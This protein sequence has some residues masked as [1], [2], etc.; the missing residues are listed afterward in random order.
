[1]KQV[2]WIKHIFRSFLKEQKG[3]SLVELLVVMVIIGML[4]ALVGPK[5]FKHVDSARRKD[6]SAQIAMFEEAIDLYRLEKH[7]YPASLEDLKEFMKKEIPQDP[8][9]K[10]Y[11]YNRPGDNGRDYDI[12]S[13]GADGAQGG[14]GKDGD[15]VSWQ[16][17]D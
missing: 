14:E 8:W 6:A 7:A 16:G 3:F 5:L 15:I 1:M 13:Y 11:I 2:A 10:P 12:I 4:A 17:L 9:D